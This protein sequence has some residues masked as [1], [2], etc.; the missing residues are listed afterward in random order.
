MKPSIV[1]FCWASSCRRRGDARQSSPLPFLWNSVG[2]WPFVS[3]TIGT[4][5]GNF[6]GIRISTP[7]LHGGSLFPRGRG[8]VQSASPADDHLA[9]DGRA[10]REPQRVAPAG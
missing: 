9:R 1:G 7:I 3:K 6:S 4:I 8:L 2:I 10:L 5:L